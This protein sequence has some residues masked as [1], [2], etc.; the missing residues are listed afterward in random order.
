MQ[1]IQRGNDEGWALQ[2]A[3]KGSTQ[4]LVRQTLDGVALLGDVHELRG[5]QIEVSHLQSAC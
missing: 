1:S 5:V 4:S 3:R 2:R